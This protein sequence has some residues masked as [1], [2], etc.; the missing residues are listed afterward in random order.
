MGSEEV[1][2]LGDEGRALDDRAGLEVVGVQIGVSNKG[3]STKSLIKQ[4]EEEYGIKEEH[5]GENFGW[6]DGEEVDDEVEEVDDEVEEVGAEVEEVDDDDEE[7]GDDDEEIDEDEDDDD[8]E[9]E[10]D[11]DDDDDD[12][13]EEE[14]DEEEEEEDDDGIVELV[15]EVP[16]RAMKAGVVTKEVQLPTPDRKVPATEEE[17][18]EEAEEPPSLVLSSDSDHPP[19][20]S[21][22]MVTAPKKV[23]EKQVE[24]E[25]G[26]GKDAVEVPDKET[27]VPLSKENEEIEEIWAGGDDDVV[28]EETK[29][30]MSSTPA[31][32]HEEVE[33]E[34]VEA[35]EGENKDVEDNFV[36]LESRME[37]GDSIVEEDVVLLEEKFDVFKKKTKR[38]KMYESAPSVSA[39]GQSKQLFTGGERVTNIIRDSVKPRT[40][41]GQI[42]VNS[43][44]VEEVK[45]EGERADLGVS[46]GAVGSIVED[47]VKPD[48]E[49]VE[50]SKEIE[51]RGVVRKDEERVVLVESEERM[52]KVAE[53][54]ELD[55][56]SM[57]IADKEEVM[58]EEEKIQKE[59]SKG[60][61]KSIVAEAIELDTEPVETSAGVAEVKEI[62]EIDTPLSV[63][64]HEAERM[65]EAQV[66]VLTKSAEDVEMKVEAT[67]IKETSGP[68]GDVQAV[69]VGELKHSKELEKAEE[70]EVKH[71]DVDRIILVN[72]EA[73]VFEGKGFEEVDKREASPVPVKPVEVQE[74]QSIEGTKAAELDSEANSEGLMLDK[75]EATAVATD[76]KL[77]E[78]KV[79][80]SK[81]PELIRPAEKE[82]SEAVTVLQPQPSHDRMPTNEN[83]QD[84]EILLVKDS[85]NEEDTSK[86]EDKEVDVPLVESSTLTVVSSNENYV[87][88]TSKTQGE[89]V[90][91]VINESPNQIPD[92]SI[93]EVTPKAGEVKGGDVLKVERT[94]TQIIEETAETGEE[95]PEEI[96]EKLEDSVETPSEEKSEV[97]EMNLSAKIEEYATSRRLTRHQMSLLSRS[98]GGTESPSTPM[99]AKKKTK[100]KT[101]PRAVKKDAP[102]TPVPM[103]ISHNTSLPTTPLRSSARIRDIGGKVPSD[104]SAVAQETSHQQESVPKSTIN[105]E[106]R[107]PSEVA[108]ELP[109]KTL[110]ESTKAPQDEESS[111]PWTL[112]LE[113]RLKKLKKGST[114]TSPSA[115]KTRK[116]SGKSASSHGSVSSP[117]RERTMSETKSMD[118][119][120]TEGRTE[121][122]PHETAVGASALPESPSIAE[123]LRHHS[124]MVSASPAARRSRR[125]STKSSSPHSSASTEI[126]L[127]PIPR[128][129]AQSEDA[130]AA[131]LSSPTHSVA[132]TVES[133]RSGRAPRRRRST[134]VGADQETGVPQ[135]GKSMEEE[136][137]EVDSVALLRAVSPTPS[138][139]STVG[140]CASGRVLRKSMRTRASMEREEPPLTPTQ[141]LQRSGRVRRRSE[142]GSPATRR[143][144]RLR[145]GSPL[146]AEALSHERSSPPNDSDSEVSGYSS[147][148]ASSRSRLSAAQEDRV[149]ELTLRSGR[150]RAKPPAVTPTKS[151]PRK[152]TRGGRSARFLRLTEE[153]EEEEGVPS[154]DT[155]FVFS[156]PKQVHS[157]PSV[158]DVPKETME[159][160]L[161][162]PKVVP[163]S[164][165]V[166]T[167]RQRPMAARYHS[168]ASLAA[169]PEHSEI[170]PST[171]PG[172][173][174]H[175]ETMDDIVQAT[176]PRRRGRS[177]L[178]GSKMSLKAIEA[179]WSS[180][181]R[182]VQRGKSKGKPVPE[183][184]EPAI[185]DKEVALSL[186][187]RTR[188]SSAGS[189]QPIEEIKDEE[190]SSEGAGA[191]KGLHPIL[192]KKGSSPTGSVVSE[193]ALDQGVDIELEDKDANR[194]KDDSD[195]LPKKRKSSS[196]KKPQPRRVIVPYKPRKSAK[197]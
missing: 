38:D 191:Q 23:E 141:E 155:S 28:K 75:S 24:V 86:Q 25:A 187:K 112:S 20:E 117:T 104:K 71:A 94:P 192:R 64:G 47:V 161:S 170:A 145:G 97:E 76:S 157:D 179:L 100:A 143:S 144:A 8:D 122:E 197:L 193:S 118:K 35:V 29:D 185:E 133:T 169:I 84:H 9:E 44:E 134:R 55:T 66:V 168:A 82:N 85:D 53:V 61:L 166:T 111:S 126:R 152:S 103:E 7:E 153:N 62:G 171:S 1:E 83:K 30:E 60:T 87:R 4:W 176:P 73:E 74:Q 43:V 156:P 78:S 39:A 32:E 180:P 54:V 130:A 33:E 135:G 52:E 136:A 27:V 186:K 18:A 95:M 80:D 138:V 91:T 110:D 17:S 162:P 102:A 131:W 182:G 41:P 178:A 177:S 173:E 190:D 174:A 70:E 63:E 154:V 21:P 125:L 158:L 150:K 132:S 50:I 68:E 19:A 124:P 26:D 121:N 6:N 181:R 195:A 128:A 65:E 196:R 15:D 40:V 79:L 147:S 184:E 139:A 194:A 159:F 183:V 22:V 167:G 58:S 96:R 14:E 140:S 119:D 137:K 116:S 113:G 89:Q 37:V 160:T 81:E 115:R 92:S 164:S 149:E 3:K 59:S 49:P 51:D 172:E 12:D 77:K 46:E 88:K 120:T 165:V 99:S 105:P 114:S 72:E 69:D 5:L 11:D 34:R 123:R 151:G 57:E 16:V 106:E 93:E 175:E 163:H 142:T 127:S 109:V 90:V 98:L 101:P 56:E 13:S 67:G 189:L 148:V 188:R 108:E 10:E 45:K 42:S 36:E 107:A 146:T 129:V 2:N 31:E 48:A